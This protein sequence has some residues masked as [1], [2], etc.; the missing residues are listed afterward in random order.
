MADPILPGQPP[1]GSESP[2]PEAI[3]VYTPRHLRKKKS[4]KIDR[5][6]TADRFLKFVN[7]DLIERGPKMQDRMGQ[8][9]KYYCIAEPKDWP[10]PNCSTAMVPIMMTAELRMRATLENA[11]KSVRPAM[12]A[13][14]LQRRNQPKEERINKL[15]DYQ[16]FV[17]NKGEPKIDDYI[18]NFCRDKA[19]FI[20]S[21]WV[22][23]DQTIH[24]V[25]VLKGLDPAVDHIP[26]LIVACKIIFPRLINATMKDKDGWTWE[27]DFLDDQQEPKTATVE[28]YD[29]DD[30]KLEAHLTWKA[31]TYDGPVFESPDYE[32][33]IYPARSAN[34]QS[35]GP[36][37]P[38]GAPYVGRFFNISVDT[39]M[40]RKADGTYDLVTD[41]D[42][43]KIKASS[44][45][46]G[47]GQPE[48]E[49]KAQK[50]EIEGTLLGTSESGDQNRRGVEIYGRLDVDGDGLEEDVILWILRKE[51]ILVK[52]V[53]L[54][55]MYP[56][57]PIMRP[58]SSTSFIP[59]PNRIDGMGLLD[60]LEE[61][62]DLSSML[63]RQHIDWGTITNIP[64]FA[65]R[66]SSG[67]KDEDI[68]LEPGIGLKLDDP[69]RDIAFPQFPQKSETYT[70]NTMGLLQ[71]FVERLTSLPDTAFGRVPTGKASALRTMGTTMSL[72]GQTDVQSE[73]IL[74]RLFYGLGQMYQMFHRLNRHYLPDQKEI[75][76]VGMAEKGQ[77]AYETIT[78][79]DI[80]G[81]VDFDFKATML[82]TNKQM[83]SQALMQTAGL[84]LSPLA[85]QAGVV[86]EQE[87]YN[88]MR[89]FM[90][91]EDQDPDKYLKRPPAKVT[92]PKLLAEEALTAITFHE[93][94]MGGPLEPAQEHLQ[95]LDGFARSDP[96]FKYF[97]DVQKTFFNNWVLQVKQVIQEEMRMQMMMQ[98][99][100][101][102]QQG[103]GQQ[104]GA[105]GGV[106]S[107]ISSDTGAGAPIQD[108]QLA[109]RSLGGV[110]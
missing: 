108:G 14:A 77:D 107:T 48:D 84:I 37:N 50:D 51:K 104:G 81:E 78:S 45:S 80:N 47:S 59:N 67:M 74:R 100:A 106:P 93:M 87:V 17:E 99:S 7:Q 15:L 10:Y 103:Q 55:E 68:R 9:A 89:D 101:Q 83:V 76:V 29:R 42:M 90:K 46:A 85:I 28:F 82:N 21:H 3:S 91:S 65:I 12:E 22:R 24:E 39:I 102:F 23:E 20:F 58:L 38:N 69:S 62:Q 72:L 35:P 71:Q 97:D 79:E 70:L 105:P 16:V 66:A 34:L 8:L 2:A 96:S 4:L 54:T 95:K 44:S 43:V 73:R 52:A 110:Q 92:G 60:I 33:I 49:S 19:A 88:L 41:E 13:K 57:L 36:S 53:M 25:R 32:D 1:V 11:A 6:A 40:R 30:G 63:L 94:P 27:A 109:D 31:R 5:Q 75:R 18:T 61:L 64:W 56:G 26:Q 98:A 86:S